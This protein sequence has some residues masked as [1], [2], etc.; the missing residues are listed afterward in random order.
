[1]KCN[2]IRLACFV[3]ALYSS[4]AP[5]ADARAIRSRIQRG[6]GCCIKICRQNRNR[7]QAVS[8]CCGSH[9]LNRNRPEQVAT[10][11][12]LALAYCPAVT[13]EEDSVGFQIPMKN[14]P[15]AIDMRNFHES[16]D[17]EFLESAALIVCDAEV[18]KV[19]NDQE[20]IQRLC[21]L[22]IASDIGYELI[23]RSHDTTVFVSKDDLEKARAICSSLQK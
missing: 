20:R 19:P 23:I 7:Q 5:I 8:P 4:F 12:E 15:I 11:T 1:M 14:C 2:Y 21:Q 10:S 16:T 22:L 3:V 13:Y 6:G 9:F 18:C 17:E